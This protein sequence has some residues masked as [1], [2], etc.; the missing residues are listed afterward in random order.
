[1]KKRILCFGDSNT[2][3]YDGQTSR[4][5]GEEVRWTGVL[6][7]LLGPDYTVIEEG[8]SGRTT[9]FADPVEGS[10]SGQTY[11]EPCL[12]SANPLALVVLMLGT[13]D[14]KDRFGCNAYQISQSAKR[15]GEMILRRDYAPYDA[16]ELLLV[17]PIEM[18]GAI[19]VEND[20]QNFSQAS[21]ERTAEFSDH[22]AERARE[23]SC[24]FLD[25][26][27][28]AAPG[29][30]DGVHLDAQNH[31]KLAEALYTKILDILE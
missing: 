12:E 4:R 5:F 16:P 26:A 2:W 27:A 13:N 10:K 6:Q 22:F 14:T 1:M 8:Q 3:G 23:L 21:A 24:H 30:A 25:A 18:D 19:L 15:L 7:N 28:Y 29:L 11:L 31:A 17:S 9:V 20:D